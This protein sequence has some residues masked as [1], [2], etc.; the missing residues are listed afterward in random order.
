MIK[1]YFLLLTFLI[2]CFAQNSFAQG[3]CFSNALTLSTQLQVNAFPQNYPDCS[4]ILGDVNI[5]G[6]VE[7]VANQRAIYKETTRD[8]KM[9]TSIGKTIDT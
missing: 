8:Q 5:G 4:I 2:I 3:S 6:T 7:N 9:A 1:N